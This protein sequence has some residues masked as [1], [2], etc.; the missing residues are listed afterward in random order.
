MEAAS[1]L[2]VDTEVVDTWDRVLQLWDTNDVELSYPLTLV[3]PLP[4][5]WCAPSLTSS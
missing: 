2:G 1:K 5:W 4:S 3:R